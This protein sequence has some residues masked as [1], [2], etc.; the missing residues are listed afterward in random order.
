MEFSHIILSAG[1]DH[2]AVVKQKSFTVVLNMSFSVA[3]VN[4][5]LIMPKHKL[6]LTSD[7]SVKKLLC[8]DPNRQVLKT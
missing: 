2:P 5:I 8:D 4:L 6:N 7:P 3:Q 1:P